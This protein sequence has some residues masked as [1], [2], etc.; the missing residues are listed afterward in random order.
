MYRL[1][2]YRFF[3]SCSWGGFFLPKVKELFTHQTFFF[4]FILIGGFSSNQGTDTSII[5]FFFNPERSF[6]SN[7]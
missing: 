4:S 2:I 3:H 1:N 7:Q 5:S 6:I